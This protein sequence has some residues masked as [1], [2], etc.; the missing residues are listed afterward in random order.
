M[1]IKVLQSFTLE[2]G[3]AEVGSV[4]ELDNTNAFTLIHRGLAEEAEQE[5]VQEAPLEKKVSHN[6][7]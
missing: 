2:T 1:K 3:I 5:A 4:I 6:K 7:K